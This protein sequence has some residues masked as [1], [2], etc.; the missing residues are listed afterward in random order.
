[1]EKAELLTGQLRSGTRELI[2]QAVQVDLTGFLSQY[3]KMTDDQKRPLIFRNGNLPQMEIITG[4]GS[5]DI[6]VPKIRGR[7]G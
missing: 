3:R 7:G 5:V 6:K 1:M 4:L 2:A